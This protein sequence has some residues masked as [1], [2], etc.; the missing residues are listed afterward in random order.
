MC[1]TVLQYGTRASAITE[2]H[3]KFKIV[4]MQHRV[5]CAMARDSS[6]RRP[7]ES[8][9]RLPSVLEPKHTQMG[10]PTHEVRTRAYIQTHTNTQTPHKHTTNTHRSPRKVW[11]T[12]TPC[13]LIRFYRVRQTKRSSWWCV[14]S[15][16]PIGFCITRDDM[17]PP[18][19]CVL[20]VTATRNVRAV[21][22][23]SGHRLCLGH[24]RS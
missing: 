17:E 14:E 1:C 13:Y 22:G 7:R 5:L 6:G 19:V 18:C 11:C 16:S 12:L 9:S 4:K 10:P 15:L 20:F 24:D 8:L 2:Q 3:F 23:G 21:G